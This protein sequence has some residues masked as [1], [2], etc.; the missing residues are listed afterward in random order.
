MGKTVM[1]GD[2][3][4]DELASGGRSLLV[5]N[6]RLMI[7]QLSRNM[8]ER[9]FG[10]G[11]RAAGF[12]PAPHHGLQISS[13]QTEYSRVVRKNV[14]ETTEAS[15]VIVDEGHLH[16]GKQSQAVVNKYLDQ[17]A[18]I[19]YLTATPIG[20]N[21]IA[22]VLIQAGVNSEGRACGALLPARHFGPDEPDLA[23]IGRKSLTD[24]L[25]ATEEEQRKLIMV[26]G[27]FARVFDWFRRMNPAEK[28]T[29]LF[30]PG[31]GESLWFAEQFFSQGVTAA[32][33]DGDEVWING[34]SYASD[35]KARDAVF[36]GSKSGDIKVVT[37]RFVLREGFD[38]PWI[39]HVVLACV[40][41]S[42]QSYLQSVGRGL[43]A[44][45]GLEE[46]TI[47][48]HG[49]NWWK[50]G[51]VNADR[52]WKLTDTARSLAIERQVR[53][54]QKQDKEPF[55]C[56]RCAAILMRP[57][58]ACGFTV[59]VGRKSRPVAQADGSLR[60]YRGDI[61]R[62][63]VRTGEERP[64]TVKLWMK[65]YYRA[66]NSNRTFDQARTHFM[67]VHGY[68]PPPDLPMMPRVGDELSWKRRVNQVDKAELI[69][70]EG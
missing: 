29:I 63:R 10:Y 60:E 58:C 53:L 4:A 50:H 1:A 27:I 31:V 66:K 59:D 2:L 11:I 69:Q 9:G 15:L 44:Y 68:Y 36:E 28:P 46:V 38:A 40:F 54:E 35:R 52:E 7:D 33:V 20:M 17:G 8:D 45:P 23:H 42:L 48:D 61:F 32:H 39:A 65:E 25:D 19:V 13:I 5:T 47:Q 64:D 37:N 49:G 51:S 43:R 14:W 18:T 22:D 24:L 12:H 56:P 3:I 26:P 34:H 67:K 70:K 57:N 41:S 62:P 6:R 21:D 55:R 16:G 30:A